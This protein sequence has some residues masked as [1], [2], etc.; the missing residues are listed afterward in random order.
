MANAL[1]P[2]DFY[3]AQ[4][5]GINDFRQEEQ[6]NQD[7]SE[8]DPSQG[9]GLPNVRATHNLRKGKAPLT[10]LIPSR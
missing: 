8:H 10:P 2:W 9:C 3:G 5:R 1:R 6:R 7:D 4:Q